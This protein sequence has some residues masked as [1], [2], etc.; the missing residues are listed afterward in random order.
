MTGVLHP[1]RDRKMVVADLVIA[2]LN[3]E[4]QVLPAIG[5]LDER[6]YALLVKL[7]A[8]GGNL[9]WGVARVWHL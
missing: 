2:G 3:I 8:A 6:T 9:L 7:L 4:D 1:A 5:S